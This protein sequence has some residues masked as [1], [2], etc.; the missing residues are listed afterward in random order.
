MIVECVV[1]SHQLPHQLTRK[2]L[3]KLLPKLPHQHLA[4]LKGLFHLRQLKLRVRHLQ[5]RQ[6][7][8][9]LRLVLKPQLKLVLKPQLKLQPTLKRRLKL[10][11]KPQLK[12]VLKP[13]LK[14]KLVLKP[15]LKLVLKPQL[16][17]VLKPQPQ[18]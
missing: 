13:Q 16:R 7:K 6:P 18:P 10:V 15:Q 17:L 9:Q 5:I 2:H 8:P 3:L 14:L 1:I 11:L 4:Q 12:L